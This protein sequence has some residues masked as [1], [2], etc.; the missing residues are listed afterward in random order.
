MAR[1]QNTG[2]RLGI[3]DEE[4]RLIWGFYARHW[5]HV[6]DN[7]GMPGA[8]D[9]DL[10]ESQHGLDLWEIEDFTAAPTFEAAQRYFSARHPVIDPIIGLLRIERPEPQTRRRRKKKP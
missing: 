3:F 5:E 4:P 7:L 9:L 2:T 1:K 6:K 8:N 10:F